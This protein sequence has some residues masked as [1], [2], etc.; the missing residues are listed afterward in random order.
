MTQ[1]IKALFLVLVLSQGAC[2]ESVSSVKSKEEAISWFSE[3]GKQLEQVL[4]MLLAHPKISRVE[5][6]RMQFIPK[7]G[8]FSATDEDA[9]KSLLQQSKQLGVKAI[10]VARRGNVIDGDLLGIDMVLISEGLT[11]KGYALTVEYIPD[12]GYI[13]KAKK[14]GIL[15]Q[16]LNKKSWYLV[17]YL[18]N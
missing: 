7:Y 12:S 10:S 8:E 3:N 17:E 6:M 9:Y 15:Y 13:E 11:T 16:Q 18:N 4:E 14:H 1:I 5:D 2:A